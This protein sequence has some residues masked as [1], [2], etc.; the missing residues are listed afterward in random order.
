MP[1]RPAT[2][3]TVNGPCVRAYARHQI[4]ERLVD[5]IG[6]R[7]GQSGRQ[8]EAERV[9]QPRRV[10]G[11]RVA[12]AGR[13]HAPLRDQLG[14]PR[15]RIFRRAGARARRGRAARDR[16]A[17]HGDRRRCGRA[18]SARAA[19]TRARAPRAL[20]DRAAPGAPRHR[21]DRAAGRGRA[22]VR[23]RGAPRAAR[24]LRTCTPRSSRTAATARTG[25]R[26]WSRPERHAPSGERMSASTSRSAGRSNTSRRHSR[27]VS[28]SI[29]KAG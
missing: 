22:R 28:S 3:S 8:R 13:D 15:F 18:G 17:G 20:R 9:A 11:R 2:S 7:G 12:G 10:L 6:E 27:V 5:R 29:G 21:A 14:Q 26:A 25:T 19:A 24:R 23:R 16:R 4:V 1:S